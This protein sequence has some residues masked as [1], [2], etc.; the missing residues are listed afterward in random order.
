M[1]YVTAASFQTF[2]QLILSKAK[3]SRSKFFSLSNWC[4]YCSSIVNVPFPY[5]YIH[6]CTLI[7]RT[8]AVYY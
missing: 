3:Y 4:P 2:W 1:P 8:I 6:S 5:E 7:L